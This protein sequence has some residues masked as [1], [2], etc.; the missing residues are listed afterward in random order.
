MEWERKSFV[1][2]KTFRD[3]IDVL[4]AEDQLEAYKAI[5]DYGFRGI[6]YTGNNALI[7]LIMCGAQPA[8]FTNYKKF[9]GGKTGGAPQGNQNARK[10]PDENA[11]ENENENG[12]GCSRLFDVQPTN[13]LKQPTNNLKQPTNNLKQPKTTYEEPEGDIYDFARSIGCKVDEH[14]IIYDGADEE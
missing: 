7:K 12:L 11:N 6:E 9:I 4:P 14:G 10:R 13:N 2:Y 8:I 1:F 5:T 3:Q